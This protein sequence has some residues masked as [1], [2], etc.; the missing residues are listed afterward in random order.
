MSA[1]RRSLLYRMGEAFSCE[2]CT[3]VDSAFCGGAKMVCI[4]GKEVTVY[5]W[6][7][8][9]SAIGMSSQGLTVIIMV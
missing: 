7:H 1:G 4:V 6:W 3:C 9:V 5:S 8:V 2:A